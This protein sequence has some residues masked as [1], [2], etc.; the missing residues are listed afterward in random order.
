MCVCVCEC[1]HSW[2]WRAESL[3]LAVV[4][5]VS[6]VIPLKRQTGSGTRC[7]KQEDFTYQNIPALEL[8]KRA[9]SLQNPLL[10]LLRGANGSLSKLL[11]ADCSG[12][13]QVDLLSGLQPSFHSI[14]VSSQTQTC[15]HASLSSPN[16]AS[17]TSSSSGPVQKPKNTHA[18][19]SATSISV[20]V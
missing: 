13:V 2:K 1:L 12:R 5:G 14:Q 7:R 20:G 18:R 4:P 15:L 8:K 6:A 11:I 16:P 9:K 10:N 3:H 17:F 19:F